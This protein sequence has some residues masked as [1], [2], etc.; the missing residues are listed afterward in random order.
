MR[1]CTALHFSVLYLLSVFE[2]WNEFACCG[3]VDV[4]MELP[5]FQPSWICSQQIEGCHVRPGFSSVKVYLPVLPES[6]ASNYDE[7]DIE[8]RRLGAKAWKRTSTSTNSSRV[9][10]LEE[11]RD[12]SYEVRVRATGDHGRSL[13]TTA[14][15]FLLLSKGKKSRLS[16]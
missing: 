1:A 7:F 4:D 14:L 8:W 5:K 11:L 12:G 3:C 15:R 9:T 16:L 2:A 13:Y 6:V 10:L